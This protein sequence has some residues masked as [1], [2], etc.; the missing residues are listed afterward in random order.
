MS[1]VA[2]AAPMTPS[3]G[4]NNWWK[5]EVNASNPPRDAS[6]QSIWIAACAWQRE[7]D[8]EL[9]EHHVNGPGPLRTQLAATIREQEGG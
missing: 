2:G 4:F 5:V 9:V 6:G 8:A 3:E 7:R 1:F